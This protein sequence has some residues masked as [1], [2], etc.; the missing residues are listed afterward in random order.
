MELF[1]Q[2][3]PIAE[4]RFGKR[5][6]TRDFNAEGVVPMVGDT[7]TLMFLPEKES[8][9]FECQSRHWDLSREGGS[10]QLRVVIEVQSPS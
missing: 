7:I 4:A 3:G 5:S 9:N 2:F 6:G 1:L 8:V 10:P